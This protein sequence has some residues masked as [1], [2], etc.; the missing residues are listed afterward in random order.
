MF[1]DELYVLLGNK[2]FKNFPKKIF[3][4]KIIDF[5]DELS[6]CIL[7]NKEKLKFPEIISFGFWCRKKNLLQIKNN[8]KDEHLRIGKGSIFHIAP[9]NVPINFAYSLVI[10]LLAGN[11]N[12]VRVH[13]KNCEITKT[14]CNFMNKIL[15]KKKFNSLKKF[16]LIIN[17]DSSSNHTDKYS[18]ISDSRIIWGGDKTVNL[19]K[20]KK[21]KIDSF[22]ISF[23]DRFSLSILNL[24][25]INQSNLK[26]LAT[27][28]YNDVY[29]M[30]QAACSSPH[31]IIWIN[32]K[33]KLNIIEKF[34]ENLFHL[35]KKNII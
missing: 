23:P 17:Y 34:W 19:I 22:D 8:F 32:Y 11:H 25:K 21:M 9:K 10:G 18:K 27:K 31:L 16:I 5:F 6:K 14:I 28:F 20:S 13:S 4:S 3:D 2:K 24:Q 33:N 30:D 15:K 35:V 26:D 7:S 12:I 1:K 29:V